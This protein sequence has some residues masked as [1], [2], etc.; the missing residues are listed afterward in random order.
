[1]TDNRKLPIIAGVEITTDEEG[2]F[3]LNALHRA[4]LAENPDIH[5]NS[6]QPSDWLKLE[7]AQALVTEISNSEDF[8]APAVVSN[9]G[10]YGGTFVHELLAVSYASWIST[11]FQIKVNQTFIDYRTG[12]LV[13]APDQVTR[14]DLANMILDAEREKEILITENREQAVQITDMAPKVEFHDHVSKAVNAQTFRDVAK[15]L[16]TGRNRFTAWLR[17]I[18]VLSK[19]NLPYQRYEEAGYFRVVEKKRKDPKTGEFLTYT[20]T[21]VTS[22]GLIYLQRKWAESQEEA[23]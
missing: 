21:L 13:P 18:S 12:K 16:R 3:N 23:A 4:H 14:S 7:G 6:K 8:G 20:Q 10:R 9:P 17:E 5:R 15:V 2:R 22:K 1:M 11:A 19:D